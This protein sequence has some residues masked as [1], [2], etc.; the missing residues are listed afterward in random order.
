MDGGPVQAALVAVADAG[1]DRPIEAIR[2][3]PSALAG[4]GIGEIVD[5]YEGIVR[6]FD[7]PPIL[8]GHSF[9][10]LFVQLLLDRGLGAGG[11][12]ID[13][14]P[15]KGVL[16]LQPTSLLSVGRVLLVPFG[17]RKVVHWTFTE[18][19]YAIERD[20]HC[21]RASFN[22]RRFGDDWSYYFQIAIKAHPDIMYERGTRGIQSFGS[23]G[24]S[25]STGGF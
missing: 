23:M 13:S 11:I 1:K 7:D 2:A 8:I 16:A 21:W 5:H 22:H 9:G 14:A 3:D 6:S 19:R 12:A 10:G 15:P 4:L 18:Y 20:L 25:L 24:S 17:W